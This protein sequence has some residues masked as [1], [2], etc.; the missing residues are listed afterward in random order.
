M[1]LLPKSF[2]LND[3]V[4]SISKNLLG[5]VLVTNINNVEIKTRIIETEAYR[6]P[7]DRASHSYNNRFTERTRVMYEEGG[8]AYIYISYGQHF[9]LNV[10][11]APESTPHAVLIRAVEPLTEI[12]LLKNRRNTFKDNYILTGGPG[13]VCQAL[14]IDKRHNSVKLYDKKSEIS[15]WDDGYKVEEV[16]SSPRVGM[17]IHVGEA[18]HLPW[19]FYLH[20]N[21]YVSRPLLP[22]YNW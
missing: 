9:M 18:S 2:Y 14:L 8:V 5:K 17:S 1:K 6:G 11:T 21:K 15:I 19:R 7:E 10:V 22:S 20:Q 16:M 3:D 12:D 4:V 13:K